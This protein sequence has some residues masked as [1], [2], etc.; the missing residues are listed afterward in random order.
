M[1]SGSAKIELQIKN[2]NME[3]CKLLKT[4]KIEE[5]KP[6]LNVFGYSSA[7]MNKDIDLVATAQENTVVY[8]LK[9][10]DIL[11]CLDKNMLDF[12]SFTEQR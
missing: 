3:I 10:K 6:N 7:I 2:N 1:N 4:L 11:E 9:R 8:L 5:G 12:E